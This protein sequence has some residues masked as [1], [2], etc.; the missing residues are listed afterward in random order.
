MSY[1]KDYAIRDSH[2]GWAVRFEDGTWLCRAHG[3]VCA[4]NASDAYIYESKEECENIL[5]NL[6]TDQGKYMKFLLPA[7]V[8]EAWEPVCETLRSEIKLLK[9]ANVVSY[10]DISDLRDELESAVSK[11]KGWQEKGR[12]NHSDVN[13]KALASLLGCSV[14]EAP[15]RLLPKEL[16]PLPNSKTNG[17]F[18]DH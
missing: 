11:I 14:E 8:V 16:P 13:W 4:D 3:W 7:K 10:F 17:D 5:D 18:N 2:P 12:H 1:K 6:Q 9:E 15:A